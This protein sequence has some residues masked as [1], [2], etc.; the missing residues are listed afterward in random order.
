MKK[1]LALLILTSIAFTSAMAQARGGTQSRGGGASPIRGQALNG[2]TGLY[3]LPTGYIGWEGNN[4]LALDIGYR[5]I[6][7]SSGTAHIPSLTLSLFKFVEAAFAY[8]IQPDRYNNDDNDDL[9]M[10]FKVK[11]PTGNT[12]IALGFNIQ[13]I[14]MSHNHN[15]NAYQPYIAISYPGNFFSMPAET[16]LVIGKTFHDNTDDT[17]IDFGMGFDI[18]LFPDVFN[19]LLHLIV[20]FANFGYSHDA[21]PGGYN[22]AAWR[23]VF[24]VGF[25]FDLSQLPPFTKY[26]F[27]LDAA[28]NDILDDG[29]RS[30]T[31]GVV[32]GI[33]LM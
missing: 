33:P 15:Y 21:W 20:D 3:T 10:G 23:G 27:V 4:D 29:S 31:F 32:F 25:R 22:A 17:N 26:K 7:N 19:K 28:F 16:T 5:A 6:F 13:L 1:I 8:D 30:F 2:T 14:N 18:V 24:N 12:A 11:L 9:L